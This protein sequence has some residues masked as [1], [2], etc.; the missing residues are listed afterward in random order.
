MNHATRGAGFGAALFAG[1]L[2]MGCDTAP[3]AAPAPAIASADATDW[4]KLAQLRIAFGHQSVGF[5]LL[6]GLTAQAEIAAAPI[7]VAETRESFAAPAIHHFRVGVNGAPL[8]K[9]EDFDA[10]M[11]GGLA[12]TTDIALV[13]L[14]YIDFNDAV[15]AR[16]IAAR[17]IED[18]AQL[19]EAFPNVRFVPVTVPLTSVQTGPKALIKKLLGRKPAGY[20][21]NTRRQQFN[22]ALREH[23]QAQGESSLLFDLAALESGH[24]RH[25]IT[26]DGKQV[27]VADPALL[28]DGAHL[29]Q[30]GQAL[31]GGALAHHL[32]T[33]MR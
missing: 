31:L 5:N 1:L 25:V 33:L 29:N 27:E 22:D 16:Q 9:L 6:D 11:R 32:A 30:R 18:Y 7:A 19:S 21:E 2:L 3:V 15:D 4:Q 10:A 20:A 23:Y 17:Y 12:A 13:K 28:E 24:A 8:G 14:C 26:D